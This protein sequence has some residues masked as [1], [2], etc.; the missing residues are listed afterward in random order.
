MSTTTQGVGAFVGSSPC[1]APAKFRNV[2]VVD[3][4]PA[5]RRL[6]SEILGSAGYEVALAAN[7]AEALGVLQRD[8]PSF[9]ITDWDM[10]L[11]D[12]AELCRLVRLGELPRYVY[13][14]IL[15][16]SSTNHLVDGLSSG[17]DDFIAKPVKAQELLA[18][19]HAGARVLDLE[20]RLRL[21]AA[22]DP[23]TE[24]LNR[25]SFFEILDTEWRRSRRT[26]SLLSCAMIDVDLFKRINDTHGHLVGD[27]VIKS[28]SEL[29]KGCSRESDCVGRYGGEEFA[30]MLPDTDEQG[31]ILWAERCRLA[32]AEAS[33]LVDEAE[34]QVTVSVGV[35]QRDDNTDTPDKLLDASDRA[36]L[37][38][39]KSGRNRVVAF[40]SRVSS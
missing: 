5:M 18:R 23:M 16:G 39:K 10:P 28:V 24:L 21:L 27:T 19:M 40:G 14:V 7:G 31:A 9:L 25:R 37:E 30:V 4:D 36:L 22:L 34:V 15:T 32:V 1:A 2:L 11:L 8:V 6:L 12:G 13:I 3:D 29:L 26:G 17:A 33:V 38:A 20:E 35:A